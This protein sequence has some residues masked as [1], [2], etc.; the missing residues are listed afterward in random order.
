MFKD[1]FC[2]LDLTRSVFSTPMTSYLCGWLQSRDV[3]WASASGS[4]IVKGGGW[5]W[6]WS[7]YCLLGALYLFSRI[8]ITMTHNVE[9]F[10]PSLQVRKWPQWHYVNCLRLH[11]Y[12]VA[13]T[14]SGL[15]ELKAHFLLT[16][17]F[18]PNCSLLSSSAFL[19][20]FEPKI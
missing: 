14:C 10:L 9:R 13:D 16:L 11:N 15:S 2:F 3:G 18:P 1:Q 7:I 20:G 5:E 6:T 4:G 12:S 8:I 17:L 19:M